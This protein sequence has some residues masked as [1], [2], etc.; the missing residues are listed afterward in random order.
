LKRNQIRG[1]RIVREAGEP[2]E[3][4][5][6]LDHYDAAGNLIDCLGRYP[7]LT[8][9]REAFDDAVRM[10]PHRRV[11]LRHGGPVIVRHEPP[12]R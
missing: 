4:P 5:F 10:R 6:G 7:D 8:T 1:V 9:G 11:C 3:L 2:T 12:P